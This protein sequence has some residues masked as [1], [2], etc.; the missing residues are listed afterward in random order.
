MISGAPFRRISLIGVGLIGGSWGLA[1]K[2]RAFTGRLTGF[3]RPPVL[4]RALAVGAIDEAAPDLAAAVRGADLVIL[5]M[6]VAAI[7]EQLPKVKESASPRALVTDTG[8]TKR[9]ILEQAGQFFSD[10]PLFVGGHPLA[11]KEQS[12]IE[13]ADGALFEGAQY[14]LSA[15]NA[16]DLDDERV[17][18]FLNLIE[19]VG[20]RPYL[21][22]AGTHDRGLAF[23]SHLP[24]LVST[25]L[26]SMIADEDRSHSLPLDLAAAG[27]RDMTRLAESPY[28]IWRDVCLSNQ[29]NLQQA[30]DAL[31]RKS[32]AIKAQLAA[33]GL[34][35]EFK[36]AS[37]LRERWRKLKNRE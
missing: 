33:A 2:Q 31:I 22:D 4:D 21:C 5:A 3:D 10:G 24:Q 6:P 26:A 14:V 15:L 23:L 1:L 29:D 11:G 7:L 18:A 30:L 20:A 27:F 32:Q 25:A 9:M 37:E 8:S 13:K 36:Q 28:A 19:F 17:V 16:R 35:E 12:G 34:E